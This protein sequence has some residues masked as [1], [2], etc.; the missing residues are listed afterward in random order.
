MVT[1]IQ[2]IIQFGWNGINTHEWNKN[3]GSGRLPFIV[4]KYNEMVH[5]IDRG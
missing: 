4:R 3:E 5:N 1:Q 2:M